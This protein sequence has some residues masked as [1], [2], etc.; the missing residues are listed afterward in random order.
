MVM[1]HPR[2]TTTEPVQAAH[3]TIRYQTPFPHNQ[4]GI[5][6]CISGSGPMFG[7]PASSQA[8]PSSVL[9]VSTLIPGSRCRSGFACLQPTSSMFW[10]DG[11]DA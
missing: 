4:R 3:F 8:A 6:S 7:L 10:E 2:M 9:S 11:W 1:F 5:D